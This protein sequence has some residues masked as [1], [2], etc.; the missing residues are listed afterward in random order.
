MSD[1]LFFSGSDR[2]RVPEEQLIIVLATRVVLDYKRK[3]KNR[4][5]LE[6]VVEILTE[7]NNGSD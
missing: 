3:K 2:I 4:V 6:M 5:V 7:S 1:S